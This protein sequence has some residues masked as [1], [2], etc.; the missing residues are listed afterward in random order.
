MSGPVG[1]PGFIVPSDECLAAFD[2][3]LDGDVDAEDFG[4]F[5]EILGAS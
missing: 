4:R 3:D 2:V 1:A 5:Q